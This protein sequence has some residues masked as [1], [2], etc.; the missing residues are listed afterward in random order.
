[1][2]SPAFLRRALACGALWLS[3]G[4]AAAI[5]V[6]IVPPAFTRTVRVQS[7]ADRP[8]VLSNV[9]GPTL[10]TDIGTPVVH[11]DLGM[12]IGDA[13][14]ESLGFFAPILAPGSIPGL[15]RA[16]VTIQ[17]E[18]VP[19]SS[20]PVTL[21]AGGNAMVE[22][23]FFLGM[24]GSAP[25]VS[26]VPVD[27]G[28][29]GSA[30]FSVSRGVGSGRGFSSIRVIRNPGPQGRLLFQI[31]TDQAPYGDISGGFFSQTQQI[32]MAP[33][34]VI[35]IQ[36]LAQYSVSAGAGPIGSA[37]LG[38]AYVDP[39]FTIPSSFAERDSFS[40]VVSP[41]LLPVPEPA[42]A[43]LVSVALVAS[44]WLRR[45]ASLVARSADTSSR[46][47]RASAEGAHT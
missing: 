47:Q 24:S 11:G 20:F 35:E 43:L 36:L 14:A 26:L 9:P 8:V 17:A 46:S 23:V 30:L 15:G 31:R 34:E 16:D 10:L 3:L 39:S 22:F 4:A 45:R 28:T 6:P 5:A 37:V 21:S 33:D 2:R 44:S 13:T 7:L 25:G 27:I 18:T 32:L 29:V 1:M 41:N 38:Q 42:A 19:T 40:F 12:A